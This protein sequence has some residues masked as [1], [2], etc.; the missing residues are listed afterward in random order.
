MGEWGKFDA[1][2]RALVATLRQQ[3]ESVRF[4]VVIYAG[5][6]S[7]LLPATGCLPATAD[8]VNR[9]ID[10]LHA[11]GPPSGRSN[12]AEGVQAAL[13]LRP[14]FVLI[15][16]DAA[17]LPTLTLRALVKQAAKPAVVC[18]A[19]VTATGVGMAVEVK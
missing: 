3:P 14:D 4:Q 8:N 18:V 17:D 7:V 13:K 6:A 19:R 1:A 15:L 5:S 12:H 9:T 11:L 16:T 2:R 10:A